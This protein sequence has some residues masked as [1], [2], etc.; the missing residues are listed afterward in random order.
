M[1]VVVATAGKYGNKKCKY[2]IDFNL[3]RKFYIST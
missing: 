3:C 1:V 2:S